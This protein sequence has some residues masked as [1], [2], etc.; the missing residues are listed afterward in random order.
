MITANDYRNEVFNGDIGLC[1][2]DENGRLRLHLPHKQVLIERLNPA[3]LQE[4]YALTIHKSQGSEFRHVALVL[5]AGQ[6]DKLLSREL[7][8]TGITRAKE[9]L[10]LYAPTATLQAAIRQPTQ[11]STGLER[12]L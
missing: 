10:S 1:L 6:Q 7:L 8:Y 5:A 3:H 11:R 4:A 9:Q 12:F 2:E